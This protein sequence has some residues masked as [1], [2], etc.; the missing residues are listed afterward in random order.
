MKK[1]IFIF[2]LDGTITE[3]KE[4]VKNSLIFAL[5]ELGR[6][7][8]DSNNWREIMGPPLRDIFTQFLG[9]DEDNVAAAIE[10]YREYYGVKGMFECEVYAGMDEIL[11][12]LHGSGK[13][14]ILATS[15]AVYYAEKVLAHFGLDRYFTYISGTELEGRISTKAE[16]IERGLKNVGASD[17]SR[18]V[19]IGDRK[20]DILGANDVDIDSIG[21]LFGYGSRQE[22]SAAG[23]TY[24]A[25]TTGDLREMV[26]L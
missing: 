4:G 16:I 19:M 20:Y 1:D 11:R 8:P 5:R 10:K 12:G 18:A 15:K 2:D 24:I 6:P 25:A 7:V 9:F 17:L 21:V 13:T 14:V 3:S 23:A 26:A 22:L